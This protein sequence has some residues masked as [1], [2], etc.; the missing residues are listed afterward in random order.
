[1]LHLDRFPI[2]AHPVAQSEEPSVPADAH[3]VS[4]ET[5]DIPHPRGTAEQIC[6]PASI[7]GRDLSQRKP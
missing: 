1:M 3:I 2:D 5:V 4:P 6:V 7:N